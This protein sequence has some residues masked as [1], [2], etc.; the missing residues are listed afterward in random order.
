MK[1]FKGANPRCI[2]VDFVRWHS[3]ADWMEPPSDDES[4]EPVV[5]DSVSSRGHLSMYKAVIVIC[6]AGVQEICGERSEICSFC[7]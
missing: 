6:C 2:L 7:H 4:K 3:P 1:V 5:G